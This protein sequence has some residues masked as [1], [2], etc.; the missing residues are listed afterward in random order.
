MTGMSAA[1]IQARRNRAKQLFAQGYSRRD[2]AAKLNVSYRTV[3]RHL[4]ATGA[5][6]RPTRAPS[7]PQVECT[8]CGRML[9]RKEQRYIDHATT[10]GGAVVCTN[11]GLPLPVVDDHPLAYSRRINQVATLASVAQD[12]DSECIKAYLASLSTEEV[13]AIATFALVAIDLDRPKRELWPD[14]TKELGVGA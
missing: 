8:V 2:I 6:A 4:A 11:S 3:E 13:Q 5:V 14:W 7:G 1:D 9:S 10:P 12:Q